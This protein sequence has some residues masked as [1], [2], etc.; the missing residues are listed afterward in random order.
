MTFD[1]FLTKR[2]IKKS[3]IGQEQDINLTHYDKVEDEDDVLCV[4]G[5]LTQ[6]R[7]IQPWVDDHRGNVCPIDIQLVV[8]VFQVDRLD[9]KELGGVV[10]DGEGDDGEDVAKTIAHVALLEGEADGEEPLDGDG[11][12]G[13]DAAGEGDVDDGQDVGGDVGE[14][15]GEVGIREAGEEYEIRSTRFFKCFH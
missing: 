5:I 9:L 7:G 12:D 2:R 11:D 15:P 1:I 13:V 10:Q 14:Q 3:H 4:R 8:R 6:V